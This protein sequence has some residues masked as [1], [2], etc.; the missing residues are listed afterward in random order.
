LVGETGEKIGRSITD[1]SGVT[2]S[3]RILGT[4]GQSNLKSAQELRIGRIR[5]IKSL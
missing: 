2:W 3:Q 5:K 4:K 1:S